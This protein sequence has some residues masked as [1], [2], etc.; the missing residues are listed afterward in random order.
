MIRAGQTITKV[1]RVVA[2]AAAVAVVAGCVAKDRFHGYVPEPEA[3]A[4]VSIGSDTRESV[5]ATLGRP[6]SAGI[7]SGNSFYY[8][9]ST[10]RHYGASAPEEPDRQSVAIDFDANGIV[11]NIESFGLED[12]QVVVLSRRVTDSGLRDITLLSQL[13]GAVG[14]FNAADLFGAP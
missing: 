5:T 1:V 12:G 2:L 11:R 8:V 9:S 4:A 3:L 6:S 14:R 13:I 10:F 7:E